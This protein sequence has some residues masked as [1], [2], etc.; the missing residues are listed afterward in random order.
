MPYN[1]GWE[2]YGYNWYNTDETMPYSGAPYDNINLDV[3]YTD[4][5]YDASYESYDTPI[6]GTPAYGP[7]SHGLN[8]YTISKGGPGPE[9]SPAAYGPPLYDTAPPPISEPYGY[10]YGPVPPP[11]PPP[12]IGGF[13]GGIWIAALV[14]LLLLGGCY[15]L[16]SRGFFG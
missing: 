4:S 9:V 15:Y 10:G 16:Y 3:P 6:G 5:M 14:L 13:G 2:S 11:P 7:N 12:G 8:P 1:T